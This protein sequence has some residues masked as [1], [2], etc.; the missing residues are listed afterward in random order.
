ML[1]HPLDPLFGRTYRAPS[2]PIPADRPRVMPGAAPHVDPAAG[3]VA[4]RFRGKSESPGISSPVFLI[5][6]ID[7]GIEPGDHRLAPMKKG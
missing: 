6:K 3:E 5:G 4:A 2:D 1:A 7:V